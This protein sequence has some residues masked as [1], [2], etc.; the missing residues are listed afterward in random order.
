MLAGMQILKNKAM[1][2]GALLVDFA[3]AYDTVERSLIYGILTK[4]E[5]PII[6]IQIIQELHNNTTAQ[7]VVNGFTSDKFP[8]KRGIRQGCP[9]A[10]LLFILV[11]EVL[12]KMLQENEQV[13]SIQTMVE[14]QEL[15]LKSI[16]FVDDTTIFFNNENEL[17]I[18]LEE[19]SL[20]AGIS[21]LKIQPTKS[22]LISYSSKSPKSIKGIPFLEQDEIIRFLGIVIGK[23]I[24]QEIAWEWFLSKRLKRL[25]I[26]IQR[27]TS[28]TQRIQIPKVLIQARIRFFSNYYFPNR[29]T[30]TT[31]QSVLS[32][33]YH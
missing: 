24:S 10:P 23:N 25:F 5:I 14:N 22:K 28:T 11:A 12:H 6:L 21:G 3:K 9:L 32:L 8:V 16:G 27:T 18:I 17:K 33:C 26:I 19:L 2:G 15:N 4:I 1:E 7:F 30:Y 31:N 13:S 29:K 20:F